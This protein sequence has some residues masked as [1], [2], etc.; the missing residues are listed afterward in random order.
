MFHDVRE[1]RKAKPC[2]GPSHVLVQLAMLVKVC[3]YISGLAFL[4]YSCQ[5]FYLHNAVTVYPNHGATAPAQ[6]FSLP[7]LLGSEVMSGSEKSDD[8]LDHYVMVDTAGIET[9]ERKLAAGSGSSAGQASSGSSHGSS[10]CWGAVQ[11][12]AHELPETC[13]FLFFCCFVCSVIDHLNLLLKPSYRFPISVLM[14]LAGMVIGAFFLYRSKDIEGVFSTLDTLANGVQ[15]TTFFDPH[16]LLYIVLPPLLYESASSMSW[17]VLRKILPSALL[18]ATVGVLL[19]TLGTGIYVKYVIK[20]DTADPSWEAAMLLATILSATD[21]VAV[22]AS[23]ASLGAP[24][25]LSSLV[26]GESLLNDGSAV[27]LCYVFLDWVAVGEP[28]DVKLNP[29]CEGDPSGSCVFLF[30]CRMALGGIGVGILAGIL[31]QIWIQYAHLKHDWRLELGIVTVFVYGTFFCAEAFKCSGVLANVVLGFI[32]AISTNKC[33]SHDARHNHHVFFMQIGYVCNQ[34]TFLVAGV[35]SARFMWGDTQC[36]H[37]FWSGARPTLELLGLYVTIHITRASVVLLFSPLL[38]RMGYGMSWKEAAIMVFGGLRGAVGLIMGLIVEHNHYIDPQVA[39]MIAFHTAGIVVL[40]LCINGQFIDTLYTSLDPYPENPYRQQ[41]LRKILEKVEVESQKIGIKVIANDWFFQDCMFTKLFQCVPNFGSIEFD[42]AKMPVPIGIEHVDT[43]LSKLYPCAVMFR[44]E[45]VKQMEARNED[46]DSKWD[47]R[48]IEADHVFSSLMDENTEVTSKSDYLLRVESHLNKLSY[49]KEGSHGSGIYVSGFSLE[50]LRKEDDEAFGFEVEIQEFE[51]LHMIVGLFADLHQVRQVEDEGV[52]LLGMVD[53]SVGFD[54]LN[55][56]VSTNGPARDDM[57]ESECRLPLCKGDILSVQVTRRPFSEWEIEFGLP[58]EDTV[59]QRVILGPFSP[60]EL[61]PVIEFR[62]I[63]SLITTHS[64]GLTG[65][66]RSVGNTATITGALLNTGTHAVT[67]SLRG[68]AAGVGSSI[69]AIGGLGSKRINVISGGNSGKLRSSATHPNVPS[70]S[71]DSGDEYPSGG[72]DADVVAKV[73]LSFEMRPASDHDSLVEM[74]HVFFNMLMNQYTAFHESGTLCDKSLFILTQCVGEAI[75]NAN[76]EVNCR[77]ARSFLKSRRTSSDMSG[78]EMKRVFSSG[79]HGNTRNLINNV[80]GASSSKQLEL[81]TL[82]EPVLIEYLVLRKVI[83]KAGFF[84][85]FKNQSLRAFGYQHTRT[86]VECLWAFVEAHRRVVEESPAIER[87]PQFVDCIDKVV[88]EAVHDLACVREVQPF[89]FFYCKHLLA[90]RMVL[91]RRLKKLSKF[92]HDGLLSQG[93]GAAL[94]EFLLER[95]N[96]VNLWDPRKARPGAAEKE[97]ENGHR[98]SFAW[99]DVDLGPKLKRSSSM[100]EK[101]GLSPPPMRSTLTDTSVNEGD[102][103]KLPGGTGGLRKAGA[104]EP[105]SSSEEVLPPPTVNIKFVEGGPAAP[106]SPH[107]H[108]DAANIE[109]PA[110]AA[111]EPAS[112]SSPEPG[113]GTPSSSSADAAAQSAAAEVAAA[114]VFAFSAGD[115]GP[116]RA[117]GQGWTPQS[118]TPDGTQ[119]PEVKQEVLAAAGAEGG[120]MT[121]P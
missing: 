47:Q 64:S 85:N 8:A 54:C 2:S 109:L 55:G 89:R 11:R 88:A 90:L 56:R 24:A 53:N 106:L 41:H 81:E 77:S 121:E 17:H 83:I 96:E 72:K 34:V 120:A 104:A 100:L 1:V 13:A 35:V 74:F 84:D 43:T 60:A 101:D 28:T 119:A 20:M 103:P 21:P 16:A 78:D 26:E 66:T 36:S 70:G 118:L 49:K 95:L 69:Q 3:R 7:R 48:V 73:S 5:Y 92:M 46:F 116:A 15:D 115:R 33:L 98:A 37:T 82:Y 45:Q 31:L 76:R 23:L 19:N 14:F 86:K 22:V 32:F 80:I 97:P 30:F 71:T 110:T 93:D 50:A 62:S 113:A 107:P 61:Y 67:A 112:E 51:G 39:Q 59:V 57:I 114:G 63:V 38:K 65:S 105:A 87:F 79:H 10:G 75:D 4:L 94:E 91:N 108:L 40:T 27:V 58:N 25:K 117:E 9:Q 29:Y 68:M 111:G 42:E 99:Q 44:K 6:W 102:P 18:L 12:D 52:Q